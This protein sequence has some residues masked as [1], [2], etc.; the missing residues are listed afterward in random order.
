MWLG[1]SKREL[2]PDAISTPSPNLPKYFTK[3]TLQKKKDR[4]EVAEM[5]N[6]KLRTKIEDTA[7][8]PTER[9]QCEMC[10]TG[11]RISPAR[12]SQ[13]TIQGLIVFLDLSL[14]LT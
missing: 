12:W 6:K 10:S 2:T 8:F 1:F 4:E 9:N 11:E 13:Q 7:A 14:N 5:C 3:K